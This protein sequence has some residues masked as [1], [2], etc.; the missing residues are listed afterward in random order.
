MIVLSN[1]YNDRKNDMSE[2]LAKELFISHNIEVEKNNINNND[3]DLILN[4][5][6]IDVQYSENFACYGDLRVDFISA[7]TKTDNNTALGKHS[8]KIFNDFELKNNIKIN[9]RGKHFIDNYLD[10]LIVFFYNQKVD[11]NKY[12]KLNSVLKQENLM[13]DYTLLIKSSELVNLIYED[14]DKYSNRVKI[15]NK[16]NLS[17]EHGSAFIPVSVAELREKTGCLFYEKTNIDPDEVWEFL[18]S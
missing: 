5:I 15:N 11:I 10:F 12:N 14:S 3:V 9:K 13:P 6:K 1:T 16:F 17:D 18:N 7:F 2:R 8:H 4:N